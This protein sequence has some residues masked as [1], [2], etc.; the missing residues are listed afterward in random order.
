MEPTNTVSVWP[1][2]I[3]GLQAPRSWKTLGAKYP[4]IIAGWAPNKK[5]ALE[6]RREPVRRGKGF[7]RNETRRS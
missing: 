5:V 4:E 7:G 1:P 2:H 6:V 3:L